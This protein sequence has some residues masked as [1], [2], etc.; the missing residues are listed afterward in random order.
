MKRKILFL[1]IFNVFLDKIYAQNS[2]ILHASLIFPIQE[3]HT[4]A[5]SLVNLPNGDY[6]CVWFYGS[7][8]R[9]SDDVKIMGA[10]L[11]KGKKTWSEP[12]LMADTPN[13]PD[14]N[15]VLFLNHEKKLFLVWI[16]VQANKWEQSILRFR[17]S[18]DYQKSG[19]PVW[20][21]QDNILLKPDDEFAKEVNKRLKELPPPTAGWAG[22]APKYDESINIAS[23]DPTK[24][25]IGW[26]T[27]IKPLLL[28]NN[29]I[30]LPL[31][32]DGFNMSLMAISDD[33]GT[34]WHPSLPLVGRG[35]IQ[36][37]VIQKKN[38]NLYALMRDS[39]DDPSRVHE[40]ESTDLGETWKASSK[41]KIPNTASVELLVLKDGRWAFLGNDI[42]DGRYRLSLF[43]SDDEGKTWK[44]KTKLENVEPNKGSFSYPSLIQT[45]DGLIHL[46][47]SYHL[48]KDKKSIKYVIVDP[49]LIPLEP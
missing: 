26:M 11:E 47:Y 4:H 14:C 43:L 31:Y 21:W 40:S 23:N 17:T 22:Y 44:W 5:S 32:S 2:P 9:T 8:E 16:A 46:T 12:F 20:S 48:E 24:R 42:D 25:S 34:S 30:V 45:E 15:P 19:P 10:R 35:P 18:T 33:D 37:A 39:G 6:L 13:I 28:P 36:P 29:R 3:K 41:T 1:L 38:G 49:K 27:R 7:G